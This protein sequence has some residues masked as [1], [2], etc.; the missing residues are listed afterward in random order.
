MWGIHT[1]KWQ[2]HHHKDW[3]TQGRIKDQ[4]LRGQEGLDKVQQPNMDHWKNNQE[5]QQ[6][7]PKD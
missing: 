4:W 6:E 1:N 7:F 2:C 5:Y 3:S